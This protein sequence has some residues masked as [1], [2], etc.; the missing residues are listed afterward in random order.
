MT[1]CAVD[2]DGVCDALLRPELPDEL[3]DVDDVEDVEDV[4]DAP[5][6]D[7]EDVVDD[8]EVV[9]DPVAVREDPDVPDVVVPLADAWALL[10]GSSVATTADRTPPA[11]RAPTVRYRVLRLMR[12]SPRSRDA[13]E[14]MGPLWATGF[15]A[16]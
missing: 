2:D 15:R 1:A 11:T 3:D 13:L 12:C 7:P 16:R 6:D 14:G 4:D 5:V 9:P 8:P 10:P